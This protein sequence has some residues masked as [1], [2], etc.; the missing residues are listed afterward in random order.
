MNIGCDKNRYA[1]MRHWILIVVQPTIHLLGA[2]MT[3][4]R[5]GQVLR[6]M[7]PTRVRVADS[8]ASRLLV[9]MLAISWVYSA[10]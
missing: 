8:E 3:T 4:R 9:A 6:R 2:H 7:Y 10:V 1:N 5:S